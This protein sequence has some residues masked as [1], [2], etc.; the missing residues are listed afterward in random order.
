MSQS[1]V[2]CDQWS[3]SN[4]HMIREW[5]HSSK[6]IR[7][8]PSNHPLK[9]HISKCA[10]L[11]NTSCLLYPHHKERR[12]FRVFLISDC[13]SRDYS[14]LLTKA[15]MVQY[16]SSHSSL[17]PVHCSCFESCSESNQWSWV[18]CLQNPEGQARSNYQ[19]GEQTNEV[20]NQIRYSYKCLL[21]RCSNQTNGKIPHLRSWLQVLGPFAS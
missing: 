6:G 11:S 4:P 21:C 1:N 17:S 2:N 14:K 12:V 9:P 20:M 5:P 13:K 10:I 18:G 16:N 19:S 3:K 15:Y 8:W 7:L